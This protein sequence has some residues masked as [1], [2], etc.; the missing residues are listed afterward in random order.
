VSFWACGGEIFTTAHVIPAAS[1]ITQGMKTA[2]PSRPRTV[3][4]TLVE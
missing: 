3:C 2:T 4:T 1:E